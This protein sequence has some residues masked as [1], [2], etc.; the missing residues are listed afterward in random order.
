VSA[1]LRG[2]YDREIMRLALPALGALAAD[3][4]VSLV[5][6]AFVGRLGAEA[7]AAVALA[8]A[9]FAVA[10]AL[11]NFLAYGTTPLVAREV[12][13]GNIAAA[14]RMSV[15]AIYIGLTLGA[16]S[17]VVLLVAG[18]PLL[19]AMGAEG[20]VLEES[21]TYLSIRSFA[22][23][24]LMVVTVGHGVFRGFQDTRT[25]LIVTLGLNA[26]NLVLD[27]ILIFVLGWGVAGAAVATVVAQWTGALWFLGLLWVRREQMGIRLTSPTW[28]E[29]RPLLGA[30]RALIIRTGS[31]LAVLTLA[32]AV[33][34]RL[35]TEAVAAHQV[36]LQLWIFLALVWDSLAIA[37]QAMVGRVIVEDR[38]KARAIS[39]RLL[40]LGLS[41]GIA[42]GIIMAALAGLLPSL[43]TDDELVIGATTAVYAF[44]AIM[45][46]INGVV[47]VWD[48]IAIGATAFNY[49]AWSMM[50]AAV[51]A[52]LA[53]LLVIP[54]GWGLAG[55]WWGLVVLMVARAVTLSWWYV[56]GPLGAGR[57][58]ALSSPAA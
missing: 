16:A 11:F 25:P 15:D 5:D 31:L 7:L 43:F 22:L 46:P 52:G 50:G 56:R 37:A 19:A 35:G 20:G 49:L 8:S 55:V 28:S 54:M 23:P 41:S 27:P 9:V 10:F 39:D 1:F 44:V 53:L 36:L 45:Q 13:R 12:G 51:V 58:R 48:G 6:T 26:V 32:T 21:V 24:A 18:Q 29:L 42:L 3:P 2:P 57:G 14:G 30:G 47:F 40:A 34:A 38:V 4:L 33:A 17:L